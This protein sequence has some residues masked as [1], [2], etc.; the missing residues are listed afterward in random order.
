MVAGGAGVRGKHDGSDANFLV[1][2]SKPLPDL[3]LSEGLD[4]GRFWAGRI[5]TFLIEDCANLSIAYRAATRPGFRQ[6]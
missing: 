1:H 5:K 3:H 2:S 6:I 4:S